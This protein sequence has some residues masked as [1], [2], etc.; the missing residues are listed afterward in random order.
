MPIRVLPSTLVDQIAAGEVV[1]RPASVAKELIEN[2][3]DAGARAIEVEVERGGL[4]LI[5]IRDDGCGI[6]VEELPLALSRHA[7][8]KLSTLEDL[9]AIQ[10]LGFR[11]EALPS[12]ASVSRFQMTSRTAQDAHG[13]RVTVDAGV[14][15]A[16][17]PA[18]HPV[19][20]TLEVRDLFHQVP[21]RRKF[22]R[23]E[24][25]EF[26]HL[27]GMVERLALARPDVAISL[28]HNGRRVLAVTAAN[29]R[30]AEA[31]RIATV[32]DEDFVAHSLHLEHEAVG[33][34]LEGW[35]G[36]PT[37]ARGV[38]DR[39][40]LFVNGRLLRD[41]FLASA[42]RVGYRDVL[43]HGRHP[44]YVLHLTLD[45]QRV[46]VNAHPQK[47]EVRFRDPGTVHDFVR[48]TVDQA[49]AATRP[50][51]GAGPGAVHFSAAGLE[52]SSPPA[53]AGG[54][55][56]PALSPWSPPP[57]EQHTLPV[58]PARATT[59]YAAGAGIGGRHDWTRT[60]WSGGQSVFAETDVTESEAARA[61][62]AVGGF[63]GAG[64]A[65]PGHAGESAP[66]GSTPSADPPLGFAIGQVL[67]LYIL[68][69]AR[70]TMVL[71]DQHAAHERVIYE[72]MKAAYAAGGIA[73]QA[74]LVPQSVEVSASAMEVALEHAEA[75]ANIGL[76][77]TP[78]GPR[79][80]LLREVPAVFGTKDL[81]GLLR[82]A[83]AE[84][85]EK[86]SAEA[87]EGA[88]HQL[89]A[90]MACHAAV[91]AHRPLS[92]LEM[93]ALL[94]EMEKTDRSDQC[95]HGRPTWVRLSVEDL[96]R[97]FLRGR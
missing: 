10:S 12:I 72:Q 44:A 39:Q 5:R 78:G 2:S 88:S 47:L 51:D 97:L 83:L 65:E 15:G 62:M 73:R 34:R 40:F 28:T 79:T 85:A 74:L 30:E 25:T 91:R 50:R 67:G 80:L 43:F 46:D 14:V 64:V 16:A 9:A 13:W 31:R 77:V 63:A 95:N 87:L 24:S 58:Y 27:Y 48:R 82:D 60:A 86:G 22:M 71:V 52:E 57:P 11:G 70:G 53:A 92:L 33:L 21:A 55:S 89:F 59:A 20:T 56:S 66:A 81:G 93:N 41:R 35:L 69:Q 1:E 84:L 6:P 19:G 37:A 42:V 4:S 45:P 75:L 68:S 76:V 54:G 61:A 18:P 38:A 36:L 90:T 3:L 32:L 26:Q 94:R 49:L 96:D 8:S 7:T 29:T 23:S 17:A